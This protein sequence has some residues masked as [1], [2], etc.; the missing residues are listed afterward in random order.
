MKFD[1]LFLEDADIQLI[2]GDRG[3]NYPKQSD[4]M[5]AG[6]CLFL[7]AKNVTNN[8]FVFNEKVYID[9]ESDALLR[10]GKLSRGDIVVTTRGTIGNVAF[11]DDSVPFENVRINSGMMIFRASKET[12]NQRLL[13]FLLCSEFVQQQIVSLTSGSA[14]P[15][16]P[17]RDLKKFRLPR[18][19]RE[20]QD[21]ISVIVGSVAD[22]IQLN[23][24]INQTL[25]EMAQAI[26]KSWFVDFEPVKA[27]IEAKV[28]GQDP[29]RAAMCA[30]SGKTDAELDNLSPDQLAQLRAT[31]ALFP[32]ELTD[33]E[34]GPIPKGWEVKK[35]KK[36]GAVIC[37]KTPPKKDAGN[38]GG[39]VPFIK[40]PDMH[41][42][43]FATTTNDTLSQKGA[44][45]QPKKQVP[46][47]SICVSCIATVG[48]V[49]IASEDSHT[50]QQI[51]SIVPDKMSYNYYLFFSM[52]ER[53]SL[54][55]DLAS[56]GSATLNLNTG[57]FSKIPLLFPGESLL[58]EYNRNVGLCFSSILLNDR[59]SQV[60]VVLR[61]TLLPKLISGEI[62][63]N[64]VP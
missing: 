35:I 51:N 10:A 37:G 22:K 52:R 47:G 63:L 27:K 60:L 45:T 46:K 41:G 44:S 26:F 49:V 42:N 62:D 7:S 31:T 61:D 54:L 21:R 50:N 25:E 19:P 58:N 1:T 64:Q 9:K 20:I 28:G 6:Y 29:E 36:W 55:H 59:Q 40:I 8:G 43:V 24:Q 3:S 56:G 4:F 30:I 34:L 57:N 38:Y 14:V 11:Y 15:Q 33:S 13:Y 32:D 16:L 2:D 39:D 48:Q 18:I 53:T 12:W 17:A 23:R 5:E